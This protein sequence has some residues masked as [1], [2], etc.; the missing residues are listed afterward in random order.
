MYLRP[1]TH[2]L[3]PCAFFPTKKLNER[4]AQR[5]YIYLHNDQRCHPSYRLS[6]ES[7]TSYQSSYPISGWWS[8]SLFVVLSHFQGAVERLRFHSAS[9]DG[10]VM[11]KVSLASWGCL[12]FVVDVFRHVQLAELPM[13]WRSGSVALSQLMRLSIAYL[14]GWLFEPRNICEKWHSSEEFVDPVV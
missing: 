12:R 1:L 3:S 8:W 6:N 11:G 2:Q 4:Q 13:N 7:L 9:F 5:T 10:P 14:G